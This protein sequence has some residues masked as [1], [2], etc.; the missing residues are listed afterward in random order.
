MFVHARGETGLTFEIKAG[1]A[2]ISLVREN[3]TMLSSFD[4]AHL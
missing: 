3:R 4:D 1:V 2:L